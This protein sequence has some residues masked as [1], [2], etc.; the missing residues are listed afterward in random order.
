MQFSDAASKWP[1]RIEF[2]VPV[3][4]PGRVSAEANPEA[5][6]GVPGIRVAVE[7]IGSLNL[8]NGLS[9]RKR[10]VCKNAP[11]FPAHRHNGALTID[12]RR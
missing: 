8:R 12:D 10:R 5:S 11:A 2:F 3:A 1:V 6:R 4:T 7:W 9:N